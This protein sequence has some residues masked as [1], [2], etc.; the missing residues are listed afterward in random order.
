MKIT[1]LAS[2]HQPS[3]KVLCL[4]H[5]LFVLSSKGD[6]IYDNSPV[7]LTKEMGKFNLCCPTN[8]NPADFIMEVAVG[9]HGKTVLSD[10]I[11]CHKL[12]NN[13]FNSDNCK[14][15]NELNDHQSS[16]VFIHSW[17][18]FKRNNL[19]TIRDPFVF[20]LRLAFTFAV[21][22]FLTSLVGTDIGKR[23]GCPPKFDADFEPS[24]L[25]DIG[26][27]IKAEL[28]AMYTN[29][30]NIF[31]AVLF[32]L[33]NALMPTCLGFPAEMIVFKAEKYNFWYS[34]NAF[35]IGKTMSEIP[36]QIMFAF[37]FWP[38]Q[39]TLQSQIPGLWRIA[40]ISVVLLF[41][42][43]IAQSHGYIVGSLFMYN[44][45]ASVFLG[46][47]LFMVPFTLLSGLFIK[48]KNMSLLFLVITY[49]S[50]I[51]FAVEALYVSLYG[52]S[53]CGTGKSDLR[54]GRE[55]FIVWFSAMLGIYGTGDTTTHAFNGTEHTMGT[56]SEKFVEE[57]IDAIAGEFISDKNEVR[58]SIMNTFDLEDW[59]IM[60]AFIVM[61]I[62]TIITR[63]VSFAVIKLM[64]RSK[65]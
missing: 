1:V 40:V 34:E 64:V 26:N 29:A 35:F 9:E 47:S 8:F 27:E 61:F 19:V 22:L 46:P 24:Q 5:R 33:F 14:P 57:L 21:P 10:M 39:H 2:I 3:Y 51:R 62:Y 25:Q 37:I 65:N 31:F 28:T 54:E 59:Y 30:G 50:Y 11:A 32:A 44:P 16:P 53:V 15:L 63:F 12:S 60:R 13:H 18:L 7:N 42:Q 41:V 49:F 17:I 48:F 23:G 6:I 4:F 55:A 38:L 20:G 56:A 43:F 36:I 45:A 52:Y 58:S